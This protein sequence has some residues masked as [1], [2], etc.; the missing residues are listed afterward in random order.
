SETDNQTQFFTWDISDTGSGL[1]SLDVTITRDDG[2]GPVVVY[3]TTSLADASGSFN[4]DALGLGTY[5]ITVNATDADGD[6]AGDALS[7]IAT[8]LVTV[9]D[10]DTTP[11]I[12]TLGGSSGTEN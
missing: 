5:Q 4:F 7:S 12:I 10:D 3:H 6:R 9:S 11:P 1:A 8:R 2:S